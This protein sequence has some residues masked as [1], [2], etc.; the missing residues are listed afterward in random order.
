MK[1]LKNNYNYEE[2]VVKEVKNVKPYPRILICDGCDSEIEYEKSDLE[3]GA[4]GCA[5]ITCPLCGCVNYLDDNENS[6]ALTADNV[7]FPTHFWH[8]C[9]ENGAVDR[10]NN[11]EIK[12]DIKRGIEYF[13]KNKNEYHWETECGNLYVGVNR[14]ECDEQ[15]DEQYEVI[16]SNN[17]YSTFIPFEAID[18]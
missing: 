6:V 13:R 4:F 16:V 2:E 18:Y 3:V 5:T 17:Y 7:E 1:V 10:C 11:E 12:N 8:T 9:K 15:C 14:Y